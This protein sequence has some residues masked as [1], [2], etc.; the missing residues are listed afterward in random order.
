[1]TQSTKLR[2]LTGIR[3]EYGRNMAGYDIV[4]NSDK[5]DA[6][7]KKFRTYERYLIY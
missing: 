3:Q 2:Y 4:V 1:M 7:L 6:N 5:T